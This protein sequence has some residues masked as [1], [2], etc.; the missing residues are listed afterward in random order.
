MITEQKQKQTGKTMRAVRFL[1]VCVFSLLT[2]AAYYSMPVSVFTEGE[3]LLAVTMIVVG[4]G[5]FFNQ[6]INYGKR[7]IKFENLYAWL[8][9][10]VLLLATI[11]IQ[12]VGHS[13]LIVLI[14]RTLIYFGTFSILDNCLIGGITAKNSSIITD[15]K[16]IISWSEQTT[17]TQYIWTSA[18]FFIIFPMAFIK[19]LPWMTALIIEIIFIGFAISTTII[20]F[21]IIKKSLIVREELLVDEYRHYVLQTKILSVKKNEKRAQKEDLTE[22]LNTKQEAITKQEQ[23]RE[24]LVAVEVSKITLKEEIEAINVKLS[25]YDVEELEQRKVMTDNQVLNTQQEVWARGYQNNF[26]DEA[27]Q[28][29]ELKNKFQKIQV[30]L[31]HKKTNFTEITDKL[32]QL[33]TAVAQKIEKQSDQK[34]TRITFSNLKEKN[35]ED[36][37]EEQLSE[38][39]K[40]TLMNKIEK[41]TGKEQKADQDIE[42]LEK[43]ISGHQNDIEKLKQ[44]G[45]LLEKIEIPDMMY[46]ITSIQEQM[47]KH[48][49]SMEDAKRAYAD[50]LLANEELVELKQLK[51]SVEQQLSFVDELEK[52][53]REKQDVVDID[54]NSEIIKIDQRVSEILNEI[55][56]LYL[57]DEIIRKMFAENREQLRKSAEQKQQVLDTILTK[58]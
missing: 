28:W 29:E 58:K 31:E 56:E 51:Y 57:E 8:Y 25:A 17:Y 52:Q 49:A 30:E 35:Y 3:F 16:L 46:V 6:Q 9:V 44:Q 4:V 15:E 21:I 33:E 41:L 43:E 19:D 24:E 45:D 7:A 18:V 37:K 1:V 23:Q 13:E 2:A 39:E 10:L 32:V 50:E 14:S 12:I 38:K 20:S 22:E 53:K 42:S 55:S 47:A 34:Q 36:L 5:L 48:V 54:C 27:L 40:N 11:L 26:D